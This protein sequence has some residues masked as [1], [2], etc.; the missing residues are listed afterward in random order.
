MMVP[1]ILFWIA[2]VALT[3]WG[4][5]RLFPHRHSS[6]TSDAGQRPLDIL[7]R[8][9]VRGDINREQYELMKRDIGLSE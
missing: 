9:Y 3:I 6:D 5:G 4:V 7:E 8:R 2:L 1:M